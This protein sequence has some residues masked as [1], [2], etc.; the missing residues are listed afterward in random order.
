MHSE[1]Q[2]VRQVARYIGRTVEAGAATAV[3]DLARR[4]PQGPTRG[5]VPGPSH[6]LLLATL[7]R[8]T[9]TAAAARYTRERCRIAA[10]AL[11]RA[12]AQSLF[13]PMNLVLLAIVA[14]ADALLASLELD[15]CDCY[16]A[17][18]PWL[19]RAPPAAPDVSLAGVSAL[20]EPLASIT[21]AMMP[22][23]LRDAPPTADGAAVATTTTTTITTTSTST[24]AAADHDEATRPD[25]APREPAAASIAA[26]SGTQRDPDD[27]G[28][29][30]DAVDFDAGDRPVA[31]ASSRRAVSQ[32]TPMQ[33]TTLATTRHRP[34]GKPARPYKRKRVHFPSSP[35][36]HAAAAD[37]IDT[38]FGALE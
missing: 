20:Q 4:L 6:E 28:E 21:D 25:G 18:R 13:M 10:S 33:A 14:R 7:L 1:F 23:S 3:R 32:A 12:L 31:Q 34:A 24:A 8:L 36:P 35:N 15:T 11:E 19:A 27:V 16:D 29:P 9:A 37:E 5:T 38:I 22:Q 17:L 30:L 2:A 26:G